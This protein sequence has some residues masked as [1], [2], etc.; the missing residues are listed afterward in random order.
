VPN[1]VHARI[2]TAITGDGS[3]DGTFLSIIDPEG[4][5]RYRENITLF[6]Q[7]FEAVARADLAARREGS[8]VDLAPQIVH[9]RE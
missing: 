7:R 3:V 2:I 1:I 4:G 9:F 8:A 5:R 6:T